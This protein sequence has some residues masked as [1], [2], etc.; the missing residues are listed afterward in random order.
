[1]FEHVGAPHYDE[2]FAAITSLL[3]EDGMALIHS[4][5]RM[6]PPGATN[7]W[8]AK[9]IFP[10]GYSPALSEVLTA[11]EKSGLWVTDLEIWRLHYVSTLRH[12]RER[13]LKNR[14]QVARLYDERFCRMWEFYLAASEMNF[15]F[16]DLMVFQLQ[17]SKSLGSV[18]LTRDYMVDHER[19][20]RVPLETWR[21]AC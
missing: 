6:S 20:D 13:F 2:F 11:V 8:L 16:D 19:G 17:L 15:R 1:M 5:G 3:T 21:A 4:I 14:A 18:P 9:Y 12:W 7:A 10:G